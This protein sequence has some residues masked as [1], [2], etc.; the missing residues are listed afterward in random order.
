MNTSDPRWLTPDQ[1]RA[2]V[3]LVRTTV[4]LP[5]ALDA[6][7]QRDA[8]LTHVEYQLL[9]WL[10]MSADRT[11][12]M[13]RIAPLANVSLS[14]LSRL[15]DRLQRR[16]LLTRRPDP[17]DGRATLAVLT[18]AGWDKVAEAAPG[19][20]AEV[21]R[22]VFDRLTPE[23]VRQLED[24]GEAITTAVRPDLPSPFPPR[25]PEADDDVRTRGP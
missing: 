6:Q 8:D 5:A 22:L 20:V 1:T 13:S 2:W 19:H 10:S 24:I 9:S 14:H 18:D 16:G 4:W 7:L 23:Q 15:A 17:E 21:Q 25:E 3:A 11:A 12:R